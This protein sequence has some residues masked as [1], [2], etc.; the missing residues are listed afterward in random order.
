MP[1]L[2]L[3][4]SADVEVEPSNIIFNQSLLAP[5]PTLRTQAQ[6]KALH[7]IL[8]NVGK[9]KTQPIL[10]NMRNQANAPEQ[11]NPHGYGHKPLI[12]VI[13]QLQRNGL[14]TLKKGVAHLVKK[15]DGDFEKAQLSEFRASDALVKL[16]EAHGYTPKAT[17]ANPQQFVV[18]YDLNGR[19][20][21]F[22]ET[23]YSRHINEL[24]GDYC[25][26]LNA[27]QITIDGENLGHLDLVRKY[28]DWDGSKRLIHGGRSYHPFMSYPPAK[29]ERITING[30]P[31]S[32]VDYPASQLNVLYS[33]VTG[34]FL[35]PE[36]PYEVEGITRTTAKY[37]V[38]LMLNTGSMQAASLAANKNIEDQN[39][40]VRDNYS[41]DLHRIKTVSAMMKL[42]ADRNSPIAECFFK[43]KAVGQQY[44]WL[45]ANLVFEVA[46]L[47]RRMDVPALTVHDEFIVP[48]DM[49]GAVH[50]VRYT[51]AFQDVWLSYAT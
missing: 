40:L 21:P 35:Y 48:V 50:E 36:D 20:V 4:L 51:T 12:A 42:I 31:V 46:R 9:Y 25:Q 45:E 32:R 16:C 19:L 28:K 2:N 27:Q 47:L 3:F 24:M 37:L 34:R 6:R 43:G 38:N 13:R 17:A 15:N 7:C 26:F 8:S 44:A 11:Y 29:R 39:K 10:F 5:E 18:L 14:L 22:E 33:Y 1:K 49:V 23:S 30:S 41:S